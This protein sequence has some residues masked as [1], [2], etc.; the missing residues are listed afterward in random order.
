VGCIP[1]KALLNIS[2]KYEDANKHYEGL[3]IKVE[4]LNYNWGKMQV[5]KNSIVT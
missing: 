2:H 4:G 1:S 5:K 3:G